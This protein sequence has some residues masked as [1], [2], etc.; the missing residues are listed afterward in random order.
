MT[1]ISKD[2]NDGRSNEHVRIVGAPATPTTAV[3]DAG[4]VPAPVFSDGGESGERGC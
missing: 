4:A 1:A 2:G 3:A